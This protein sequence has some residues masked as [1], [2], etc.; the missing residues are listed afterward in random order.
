MNHEQWLE[1]AEIY[2]LGA[3]DGEELSQFEAHLA[4]GCPLCEGRLRETREALVQLPRSLASVEPPLRLKADLLRRIAPE[5]MVAVPERSGLRWAWWG[6]GVG[7]LAAAGLVIVLSWNLLTARNRLHNVQTQIAALQIQ[8]AQRDE[9]I[10]FLSDPQVRLI[11]LKGLPPNANA[12]GQLLWNPLSRTGLLLASGLPQI[13]TDKA[14]E[15]WGIA[16]AEPVPAGVFAVE[17]RGLAFLRLPPVPAAKN[18][19]KFAVTVEP[20]G[21]VPKPTGAMVLLGSL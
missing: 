17:E 14:Y 8:V 2:A 3:L 21:G 7:A 6:V 13:P 12:K 5:V 15:L 16:G 9:L 4:S 18:Y 11:N 1:R 20:A 10:R 19:D